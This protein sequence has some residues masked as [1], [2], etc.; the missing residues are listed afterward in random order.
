MLELKSLTRTQWFLVGIIILAISLRFWGC[1]D[2]DYSHDE[3]SALTRMQY[4]SWK[5]FYHYGIEVDGHPAGVHLFLKLLY[6]I[7][8]DSPFFIRFPFV[9]FSVLS[10][11][12]I[13][14]TGK[15]WFSESAG[16]ISA[17]FL[18]TI[19]YAIY[20]GV[21]ARPYSPG[22]LLSLL[23]LRVW[24]SIFIAERKE[25]KLFFAYG[26]LLSLLGYTHYF[27]LLFG[28]LISLVGF[29]WLKKDNLLKFIISG[30][31]AVVLYLP[32]LNIFIY[33]LNIGGLAWL[34]K[35][36]ST[37]FWEYLMY[38]FNHSNLFLGVI[39]F[40]TCFY[41]KKAFIEFTSF[42]FKKRITL[43]VLFFSHLLIGYLYSIFISPVLQYSVLIFSFPCLVLFVFSFWSEKEKYVL[44]VIGIAVLGVTSLVY[45]RDHFNWFS[46]NPTKKFFELCRDEKS[47]N[48]GRHEV[49]VSEFYKERF[50]SEFEYYSLDR[51]CTSIMDLHTLLQSSNYDKVVLGDVYDREVG[52]VYQYYPNPVYINQ[53]NGYEHF[54]FSKENKGFEKLYYSKVDLLTEL[55]M[56]SGVRLD[57]TYSLNIKL[58]Q[59]SLIRKSHDII[60]IFIELELDS[61]HEAILVTE[62]KRGEKQI[63]WM[64][65][66]SKN[67]MPLNK[68]RVCLLNSYSIPWD[69]DTLS[70]INLHS[71]IW[72][73]SKKSFK[74][75]KYGYGIRMGN[76]NKYSAFKK[77]RE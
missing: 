41:L 8:G 56:N 21:T 20:H 65:A 2:F 66:N 28:I 51:D 71:Y 14:K 73:P 68:K 24:T 17:T 53:G 42:N 25:W 19:Q 5:D 1:W 46:V 10:V 62:A 49:E 61:N 55:N 36:D 33:Q 70:G 37:F 29:F 6:S 13:Y 59:D 72:N 38:V 16:L 9:V 75:I 32:H 34:N 22:L 39:F 52:L 63:K 44:P 26:I 7:F 35:P 48:I 4:P 43:L 69:L 12:Q 76:K 67:Q 31:I 15:E 3:L 40:G 45:E 23:L 47:L 54:I 58:S 60:D 74:I 77:L 11:Y 27:G 30:V 18:A 50:G 64:G 57:A